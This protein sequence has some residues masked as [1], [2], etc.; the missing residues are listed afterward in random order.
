MDPQRRV[1]NLVQNPATAVLLFASG[2]Y[3][4]RWTRAKDIAADANSVHIPFCGSR[5]SPGGWGDGC[6][7]LLSLNP[8]APAL[9]RDTLSNPGKRIP[10]SQRVLL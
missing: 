5:H 8:P 6:A 2:N 3:D 1:W 10:F 9:S 7:F 4:P